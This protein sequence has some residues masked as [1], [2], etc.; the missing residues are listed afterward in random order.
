MTAPR[1][2]LASASSSGFATTWSIHSATWRM[3][4]SSMLR[5]VTAGV[6][7][8]MPDGSKGLRGS[9]GTVL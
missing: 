6:P 7:S 1:T 5:L 2:L 3:A 9:N 8:R 4:D